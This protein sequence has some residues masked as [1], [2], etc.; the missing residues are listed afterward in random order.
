MINNIYRYYIKKSHFGRYIYISG[1]EFDLFP[2][3][4]AS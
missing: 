4:A 3:E 1:H 2:T